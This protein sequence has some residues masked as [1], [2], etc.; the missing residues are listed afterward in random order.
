MCNTSM[1]I[2]CASVSSK[3]VT[4]STLSTMAHSNDRMSSLTWSCVVT[5]SSNGDPRARNVLYILWSV[6]S[7]ALASV[8]CFNWVIASMNSKL[9]W[10][11]VWR[12]KHSNAH[13]NLGF[14]STWFN[15]YC[16]EEIVEKWSSAADEL[17]VDDEYVDDEDD[18]EPCDCKSSCV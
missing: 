2:T 15:V 12:R 3:I 14:D 1:S 18:R 10:D 9:S 7:T 6:I 17:D 11:H 5:L 8:S 13:S 4:A 16:V